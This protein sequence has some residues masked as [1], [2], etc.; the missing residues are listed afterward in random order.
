MLGVFAHRGDRVGYCVVC[1]VVVVDV[2]DYVVVEVLYYVGYCG[3][4]FEW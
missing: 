1:V 4:D 3:F 2:D